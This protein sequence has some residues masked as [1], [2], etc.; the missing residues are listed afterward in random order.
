LAM[1]FIEIDTRIRSRLR[2]NPSFEETVDGEWF[3]KG[4]IPTFA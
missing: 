4:S 1:L 2:L 3:C